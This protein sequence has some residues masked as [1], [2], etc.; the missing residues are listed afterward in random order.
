[1]GWKPLTGSCPLD[2][3][4]RV[5]KMP[6][7]NITIEQIRKEIHQME[8]EAESPMDALD[9]ARSMVATRN[10]HVPPNTRYHVAKVEEVK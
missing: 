4:Q 10:T 8:L 3:N 7:F 9:Q 2:N 6:K 1:M 5:V